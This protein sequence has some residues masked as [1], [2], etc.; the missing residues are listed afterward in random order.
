MC[1]EESLGARAAPIINEFAVCVD[2]HLCCRGWVTD[3]E[4]T[5]GTFHTLGTVWFGS[6]SA[7]SAWCANEAVVGSDEVSVERASHAPDRGQVRSIGTSRWV[8]RDAFSSC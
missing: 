6:V 7:R 1:L 4:V 3:R 8:H 2:G 5:S